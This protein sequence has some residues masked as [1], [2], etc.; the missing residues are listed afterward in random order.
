MR[1]DGPDM[2]LHVGCHP[3][4]PLD[5]RPQQ[6]ERD[7]VA[8]DDGEAP[9][10]SRRLESRASTNDRFDLGEDR[11]DW[12]LER[13]REWSRSYAAPLLDEEWVV[14]NQPQA[15]QCGT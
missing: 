15:P 1:F 3:A 9:L 13:L 10:V 7:V 5:E 6:Y 8:R 12:S 14:E 4:Q 2:N 11:S